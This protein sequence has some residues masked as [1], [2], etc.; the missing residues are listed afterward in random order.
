MKKATGVI[1]FVLLIFFIFT[2]NNSFAAA[3]RIKWG[4]VSPRI[5]SFAY[6]T[7]IS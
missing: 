2:L 1:M 7:T 3:Y 6:L 4:A 5:G